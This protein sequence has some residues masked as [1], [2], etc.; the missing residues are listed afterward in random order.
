MK[1]SFMFLN[2]SNLTSLY[3]K[4]CLLAENYLYN[5]P[6]STIN[7]SG[8]VTEAIIKAVA[9]DATGHIQSGTLYNILGNL[10]EINVIPNNIVSDGHYIRRRN[11]DVKHEYE[12]DYNTAYQCLPK[13]YNI[14]R[15]YYI[16]YC[17]SED[18]PIKYE[19]PSKQEITDREFNKFN[20]SNPDYIKEKAN[21][22][23]DRI[24]KEKKEAEKERDKEIKKNKEKDLIIGNLTN[25]NS[26]LKHENSELNSFIESSIK[27]IDSKNREI[28][29]YKKENAQL[30]TERDKAINKLKEADTTRE[31]TIKYNKR[32]S[33]INQKID[34]NGYKIETLENDKRV[35]NNT[36][37]E[38]SKNNDIGKLNLS[39]SSQ[40]YL[41]GLNDE[42][43]EAAQALDGYV[44]VT[45]GPGTGKTKTL[46]KR[47]AYLIKEKKIDTKNVLCITFTNK[48]ASEMRDRAGKILGDLDFSQ[49]CTFH[50]FCYK[51]LRE[52]ANLINFPH[53]FSMLDEEDTSALI[54][55]IT[56]R[57]E[58]G[59]DINDKDN[60]Y[61][62]SYLKKYISTEKSKDSNKYCRYIFDYDNN[63]F[64]SLFATDDPLKLVFM[65]FIYEQRKMH[66]LQF[67]DL[68][69]AV[70]YLYKNNP[71]LAAS[72]KEQ[73]QYIMVDEFQDINQAQYD[74]I[75]ALSSKHQNLFIVGDSNQ[76]IYSWRG[77]NV[78]F[79]TSFGKNMPETK[80]VQLK[81][82]YRSSP[83][84][85]EASELLIKNNNNPEFFHIN[86]T[87]ENGPVP[88][89][90]HADSRD[91]EARWCTNQIVILKN[92]GVPLENIAIIYRLSS[93]SPS[94]Q[95]ILKEQG[96]PFTILGGSGF[97]STPEIKG[98][99]A[100]LK[101][102][103][104][105][106]DL[107]FKRT[108]SFPPKGFGLQKLSILQKYQNTYGNSLYQALKIL[109][110]KLALPEGS[111]VSSYI[112]T[113]EDIRNN[114]DYSVSDIV[115]RLINDFEI[116]EYLD[117]NDKEEAINNV[118][119]L[120][121]EIKNQES[122]YKKEG[123][124]LSLSEFLGNIATN[125]PSDKEIQKGCIT[126][127]TAHSSKG[128]EFDYVFIAGLEDNTFP[129]YCS[130]TSAMF[131]ERRLFYVAMT[132]AKRGLF[133]SNAQ[134]T[135]KSGY[136]LKNSRFLEEIKNSIN[137]T[138]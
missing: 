137:I 73:L 84:I 78:R 9:E 103:Q 51:I 24:K 113:I 89:F 19:C 68:I 36:L 74:L 72:I 132:R 95:R 138:Q 3:Y 66:T 97:Y 62:I 98:I 53:N 1:S 55:E 48:A 65:H 5:D 127:T 59:I 31:D 67:E 14:T 63:D 121:N 123:K 115:N 110:N 102:I 86:T 64:S 120:I 10:D 108:M 71:D 44:K 6:K 40:K 81:L 107:A 52:H 20:E 101:M 111:G 88:I 54:E 130:D 45:A 46:I 11:N 25:E 87:N 37:K 42:Q 109:I 12:E 22:N 118:Y 90:Y 35:T 77:S 21:L 32:L 17:S 79:I 13:L 85:L 41:E 80:T 69:Y 126:L 136:L 8:E 28:D 38:I 91:N 96:L 117:K 15:W 2:N 75:R 18:I 131:E 7:K 104:G 125:T 128:L 100:Y 26:I 124:I 56:D 49:I 116:I 16:T 23:L 27:E 119:E 29:S 99:I 82:N 135:N 94:F 50:S 4:D 114:P 47:Y 33:E 70:F 93:V 57:P 43:R 133:L 112:S 92:K 58:I 83:E 105:D 61:T 30:S 34:D 129:K 106:N 122:K 76:T 60:K 39:E 134:I